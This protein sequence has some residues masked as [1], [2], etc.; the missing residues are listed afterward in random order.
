MSLLTLF[1]LDLQSLFTP[2]EVFTGKASLPAFENPLVKITSGDAFEYDFLCLTAAGAAIAFAAPVATFELF[3]T[4]YAALGATPLIVKTPAMTQ[5]GGVWKIS[6]DFVADDTLGLAPK[7]RFF[8]VK[9]VDGGYPY[10]VATG[11]IQNLP[12]LIG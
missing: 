4:S 9:I 6:A 5:V 3:N 2:L 1:Q 12:N 7:S 8:Q 10:M 11:I